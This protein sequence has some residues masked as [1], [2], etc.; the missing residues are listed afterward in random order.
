MTLQKTITEYEN[1]NSILKAQVE[2]RQ[3]TID[4]KDLQIGILKSKVKWGGIGAGTLV[5]VLASLLLIK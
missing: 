2:N 4:E 3:E 1:N 5:A